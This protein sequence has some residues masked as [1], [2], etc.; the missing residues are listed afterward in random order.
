MKRMLLRAGSGGVTSVIPAFGKLR[1][2][3]REFEA[4]LG[5]N[6]KPCPKQNTMLR[7]F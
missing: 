2:E 5:Y 1:L 3:R 6:A 7:F 4:S